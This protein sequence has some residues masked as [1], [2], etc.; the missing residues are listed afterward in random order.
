MVTIRRVARIWKRGGLFWKSERSAIN[1]DPNFHC[2]WFRNLGRLNVVSAQIQVTSKK[3]KGLHRFWDCF[4]GQ[5][6]KIKRSFRPNSGVLQKK[7]KRSSPILRLFFRPK[8][9]NQ[10]FFPPKFRWSPKNRSWGWFFGQNRKIKRIFRPNSGD[11]QKKKSLHQFWNWF[12]GQNQKFKRL[13]GG[14]F[15]M[16]GYFQFFTKNRPQ[17]HQKRAI[18]HT[19]QANGGNSS[20]PAP[21]PLLATLLVTIVFFNRIPAF[22]FW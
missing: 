8:S 6:R 21:P 14:F 17:K 20:P 4:F 1:L 16:G 22:L 19:S 15:P 10:T 5:S 11:L 13:R 3:K 7:K 18:L 2:P 9:E 12:F